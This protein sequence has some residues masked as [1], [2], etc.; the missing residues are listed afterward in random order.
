[1]FRQFRRI[2]V[3]LVAA[4][5]LLATAST[6]ARAS[7]DVVHKA[8]SPASL[9]LAS[10]CGLICD[11]FAEAATGLAEAAYT[12]TSLLLSADAASSNDAVIR[13]ATN[14][15]AAN[16][17]RS[18]A[19]KA[20]SK[21]GKRATRADIR[22]GERTIRKYGRRY[23]KKLGRYLNKRFGKRHLRSRAGKVLSGCLI[24][25]VSSIFVDSPQLTLKHVKAGCIGGALGA[26]FGK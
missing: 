15:R 9:R 24:V 1:M 26:L 25:G 16:R 6:P 7:S 21:Q 23:V 11:A 4:A 5:G 19:R 2:L 8:D 10:G 18:Q 12:G 13:N 3:A 22:R 14:K 17:A 20:R